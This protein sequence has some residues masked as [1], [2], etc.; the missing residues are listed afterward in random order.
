MHCLL[1]VQIYYWLLIV[2]VNYNISCNNN[3][4]C[5][6]LLVKMRWFFIVCCW[7]KYIVCCLLFV[8]GLFIVCCW[9]KWDGC[10]LFVVGYNNSCDNNGHCDKRPTNNQTNT[11]T[12]TRNKKQTTMTT[13]EEKNSQARASLRFPQTLTREEITSCL[14]YGPQQ[15]QLQHQN[16]CFNSKSNGNSNNCS[17]NNCNKGSKRIFLGS[18]NRTLQYGLQ[19]KC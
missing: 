1:L 14:R 16:C 17:S 5:C 13:N 7:L 12:Y 3:G 15:Q 8:V 19:Q 11:H 9:L 10:T 2:F 4:V 6:L 18:S